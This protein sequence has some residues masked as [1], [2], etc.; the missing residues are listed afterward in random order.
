MRL[1]CCPGNSCRGL[2]TASPSLKLLAEQLL[3]QHMRVGDTAAAAAPGSQAQQ[4]EQPHDSVEDA[5]TSMALVKRE[6]QQAAPTPP[7]E[8]PA[9]KVCLL[10]QLPARDPRLCRSPPPLSH[11]TTSTPIIGLN[12]VLCLCPCHAPSLRLTRQTSP[13]C[14]CTSCPPTAAA[15]ATFRPRSRQPAGRRG[16][17]RLRAASRRRGWSRR[18]TAPS[19]AA[20]SC[21]QTPRSLMT[22]LRHCQVRVCCNAASGFA[23]A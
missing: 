20:S 7:L 11:T 3:G 16:T 1:T 5:S 21:F 6:L 12:V 8:P 4:Q 9:V 14:V 23:W 19:G 2:A 18:M 15:A 22:C 13:S 10:L 17:S